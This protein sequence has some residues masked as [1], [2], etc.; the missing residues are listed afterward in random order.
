MKKVSEVRPQEILWREPAPEGKLDL[1][2][3][4]ELRMST[5]ALYADVALPAAG[6]YEMHDLSTTDLHTFVHSFNPAI[7]PPWETRPNWEQFKAIAEKFS[8]LAAVHLGEQKDLVATPLMHDSPGEIAQPEV[9][10]WKKGE[11]EPQPGKTMP[12]LVVVNRDFGNACKMMTALGPLVAEQGVGAKGISWNAAEEYT[13]LKERLG[14][15]SAP[16][17]KP[18]AAGAGNGKT[19][20]GGHS[21]PGP[22]DQRQNGGQILGRPGKENGAL[23][24]TSQPGEGG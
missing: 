16:R 10:D 8:E 6:W 1:L 19:G 11:V 13:E 3:T 24:G 15:V 4:L 21:G 18:G 5:S 7:D 9:K 2:V 17:G 23:P 14:T 20:G 12:N 22:G